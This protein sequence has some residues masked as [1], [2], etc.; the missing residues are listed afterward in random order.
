MLYS[1]SYSYF[2]TNERTNKENMIDRLSNAPENYS[3]P[4][5]SKSS[6]T[7]SIL[8]TGRLYPKAWARIKSEPDLASDNVRLSVE[9][10]QLKTKLVFA[11]DKKGPDISRV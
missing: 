7:L 3:G 2:S 11:D 8:N 6:S 10:T 1:Y 9:N 4:G 5:S